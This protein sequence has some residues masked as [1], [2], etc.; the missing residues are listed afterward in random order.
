MKRELTGN[1]LKWIALV[2]MILDHV[3]VAL[4]TPGSGIYWAARLIGRLAFPLYCFLLVEGFVHTRDVKRYLAR[5]MVFALISELP[6]D[7]I[8]GPTTW[9][10]AISRQNVYFTLTIGLATL[11]GYVRLQNQNQPIPAVVWC[12]LMSG[13]AWILRTDYDF[14]GVAL[15]CIFYRFRQ[16]PQMRA[17]WGSGTLLLAI[18]PTEWPALLDFWLISC[19]NGRRG[20]DG[21]KWLFYAAYPV[22][23]LLLWMLKN[24]M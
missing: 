15:I 3:G 2:T 14:A 22:H 11:I 6:F 7:L 19:Y 10:E 17:V 12:M 4:L 20:N 24:I 23:L 18:S 8:H 9:V 21:W 5:L 1:D 13:L 16:E